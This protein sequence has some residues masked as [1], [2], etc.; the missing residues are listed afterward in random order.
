MR[1]T[2][3]LPLAAAGLALAACGQPAGQDANAQDAQGAPESASSEPVDLTAARS[4][5]YEIDSSHGY[6]VFSYWHQ[7]YSRPFVRYD[8][9]TATLDWNAENPEASSVSVTIDAASVNSGVSR[10]DDHMRS[11]DMFEVETFPEI[12]FES[13]SL[14]RTGANTGKMTGDLTIKGVTKP[15]TLDVV[16]NKAAYEERGESYKLG[17]S[18]RGALNRSD[19]GVDY[20]VPFVGDEVELII[21]TEF[22]SPAGE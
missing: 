13:T 3:L 2:I 22:V 16:I 9:W 12:T 19:Y 7:G 5:A 6:I 11:G 10:F 8:D 21:E 14:E 1:K 15:V 4:G 20:A 18:A 17:F